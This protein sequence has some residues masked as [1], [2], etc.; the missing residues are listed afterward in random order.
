MAFG[1]LMASVSLSI[2]E[3]SYGGVIDLFT[4]DHTGHVQIHYKDFL[5][6]PTLYKQIKDLDEVL[7]T[8]E[9]DPNVAAATPRV[10]TQTLAYGNDKSALASV[11]G[12][13]PEREKKTTFLGRKVFQGE[14][15]TGELTEDGYDRVMIG[16]G[17]AN[18]LKVSLGDEIIL[19]GQGADGSIANDIYVVSGIV[20]TKDSFEKQKIF[21]S[22][23][24]AQ[25]F[26]S[27]G[28][29]AHEIAI[30]VGHHS[31]AEEAALAVEALLANPDLSVESWQVVEKTFY[32]TM[33]A[34][35]AGNYVSIVVIMAMVAIGVLNA[36]LMSTLERT[37]EF[38]LL[39][40]V[41]TRPKQIFAMIVTETMVLGFWGCIFG[42]ICAWPLNR[43]LSIE[44]IPMPQAMDVGGIPFD[45]ILGEISFASMV[46][47]AIIVLATALIVSLLP[48][49]KAARVTPV[50]A[51]GSV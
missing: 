48:G 40:A 15:L 26:L 34:D 30:V 23:D 12:I 47:P 37:R 9:S 38:G 31:K 24:A 39:K 41:G 22:L 44:G 45:R 28:P 20:G 49:T 10:L 36:V 25:R 50:K 21:M 4:K 1:Y 27:M 11:V 6:R 5:D 33:V 19:I 8:I 18:S 35:K 42:A 14:Y 46:V 51:L 29:A 13:D 2:A 3:G 17:I 32:E 16:I 7:A 43:Y